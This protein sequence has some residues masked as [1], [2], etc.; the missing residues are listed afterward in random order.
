MKF[1]GKKKAPCNIFEIYGQL[2]V[3][4]TEEMFILTIFGLVSTILSVTWCEK[5]TQ[6]RSPLKTIK[7]CNIIC[8]CIS[9]YFPRT[10]YITSYGEIVGVRDIRRKIASLRRIYSNTLHKDYD[11]FNQFYSSALFHS[12]DRLLLLLYI[13]RF[14]SNRTE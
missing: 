11:C 13:V 12:K 7:V 10:R 4:L 8:Q 6:N 2:V 1:F 5:T 14:H 9:C 3:I